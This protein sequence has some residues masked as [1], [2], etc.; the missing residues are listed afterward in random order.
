MFLFLGLVLV[1]VLGTHDFF[2]VVVVS[3]C[4]SLRLK[5]HSEGSR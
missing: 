1:I 2:F 3:Q 4:L 5:Q